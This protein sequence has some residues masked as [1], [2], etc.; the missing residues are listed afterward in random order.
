MVKK[1]PEQPGATVPEKIHQVQESLRGLPKFL[2]G[3]CLLTSFP[4]WSGKD[5]GRL[6]REQFQFDLEGGFEHNS[7]EQ[8]SYCTCSLRK[9][10]P[11]LATRV[12]RELFVAQAHFG[13]VNARLSFCR[14]CHYMPLKPQPV[15]QLYKSRFPEDK[16]LKVAINC[17]EQRVQTQLRPNIFREMPGEPFSNCLPQYLVQDLDNEVHVCMS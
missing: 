6:W 8:L 15:R 4:L 11:R 13:S 3:K 7:V 12:T 2:L 5:C 17:Q 16:L 9:A 14:Y 1:I 10:G